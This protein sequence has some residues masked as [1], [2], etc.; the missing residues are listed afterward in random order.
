M[1]KQQMYHLVH[2]IGDSVVWE[3]ETWESLSHLKVPYVK[4][5]QFLFLDS[6]F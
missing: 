5:D 4:Y 3:P 1:S 6:I 2:E